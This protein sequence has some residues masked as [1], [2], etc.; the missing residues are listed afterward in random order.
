MPLNLNVRLSRSWPPQHHKRLQTQQEKQHASHLIS[1]QLS[2]SALLLAAAISSLLQS[3]L[4]C[5]EQHV[6]TC[7]PRS[8]PSG[9][10]PAPHNLITHKLITHTTNHTRSCCRH[11]YLPPCQPLPCPSCSHSSAQSHQAS[12]GWPRHTAA[13]ACALQPAP[14]EAHTCCPGCA[15]AAPAA[16]TAASG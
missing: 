4:T 8:C 15:A 2:V 3:H 13:A 16:A 9:T 14:P 12:L 7:Q 11:V 5:R 1:G 10:C 6:N